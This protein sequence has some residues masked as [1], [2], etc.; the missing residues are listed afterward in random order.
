LFAVDDSRR[1]TDSSFGVQM[2]PHSSPHLP[3]LRD[4]PPD[5]L[6]LAAR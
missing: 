3:S 5:V 2:L 4:Q 6:S 1:T